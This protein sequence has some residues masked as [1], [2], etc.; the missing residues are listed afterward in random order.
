MLYKSEE[1]RNTPVWKTR[2]FWIFAILLS[3]SLLFVAPVVRYLIT[4]NTVSGNPNACPP[5]QE[6]TNGCKW[7]QHR[8]PADPSKY[9]KCQWLPADSVASP[10][11][12]VPENTCPKLLPAPT[13]TLF[14]APSA[15]FTGVPPT[16]TNIFSTCTPT[17]T[18]KAT[19]GKNTYT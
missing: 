9:G 1:V 15:T 4:D 5:G 3:V 19:D 11:V 12:E 13:N 8:N 6:K 7:V 2:K 18:V 16:A 14:V 17:I 10:W